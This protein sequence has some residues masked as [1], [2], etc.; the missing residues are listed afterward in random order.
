MLK[1][2]ID[3]KLKGTKLAGEILDIISKEFQNKKLVYCAE[4]TAHT[5]A[6]LMAA[7]TSVC[8]DSKEIEAMKAWMSYVSTSAIDLKINL[9]K[10]VN[11]RNHDFINNKNKAN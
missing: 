11:E 5:L 2:S 6:S 9:E 3:E 7:F 4:F 8:F 10:Y 1:L